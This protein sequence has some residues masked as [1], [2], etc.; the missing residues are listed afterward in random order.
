MFVFI[1]K[2]LKKTVF[3]HGIGAS[4]V[5]IACAE[6]RPRF[7]LN[8]SLDTKRLGVIECKSGVFVPHIRT[9][10]REIAAGK[11]ERRNNL[12]HIGEAGAVRE[13]IGLVVLHASACSRNV[14]LS[15]V[16]PYVRPEPVSANIRLSA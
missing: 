8:F 1:Y 4:V 9:H 11:E 14:H 10:P 5:F 15:Q 3:T 12:L 2:W 13:A 16:F 7:F 6:K